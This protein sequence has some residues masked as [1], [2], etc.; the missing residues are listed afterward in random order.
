MRHKPGISKHCSTM[1][2]FYNLI[3]LDTCETYESFVGDFFLLFFLWIDST[4]WFIAVIRWDTICSLEFF[5]WLNFADIGGDNQKKKKRFWTSWG[6]KFSLLFMDIRYYSAN[7]NLQPTFFMIF[8]SQL[9]GVLVRWGVLRICKW[10]G[11]SNN[12]LGF[13]QPP[14]PPKRKKSLDQNLTLKM[15]H[16]EF[17]SH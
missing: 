17:S 4:F 10:Q 16:T 3:C 13:K 8:P 14:P 12:P 1:R 15:S 2:N 7:K 5:W 9:N 11:G 6:H